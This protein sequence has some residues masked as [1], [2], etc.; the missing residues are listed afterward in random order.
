MWAAQP[1]KKG[2]V[3]LGA[4]EQVQADAGVERAGQGEHGLGDRLARARLPADEHVALHQRDRHRLAV[5]VQPD[6][7]R[8]P[9]RELPGVAVGP[10]PRLGGRQRIA[11]DDLHL[12]QARVVGPAGDPDLA[13][14]Q[15]GGDRL[16]L[17]LD[18]GDG[19]A[20]R[21]PHQQPITRQGQPVGD[22]LWDAVVEVGESGVA[23]GEGPLSAH[24]GASLDQRGPGS[25][26]GYPPQAQQG[27]GEQ[28]DCGDPADDACQL[29][30]HDQQRSGCGQ[31]DPPA[32]Q[33]PADE[34]QQP[35]AEGH[36]CWWVQGGRGL[37]DDRRQPDPSNVVAHH[38]VVWH[39]VSFV[40]V[41]K[42]ETKPIAILGA[43]SNSTT[44]TKITAVRNR[45][46]D[47]RW[48][49]GG[50]AVAVWARTAHPPAVR[51]QR[52]GPTARAGPAML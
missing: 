11:V 41:V 15:V 12:R 23:D 46:E 49:E 2:Q 20:G 25:D 26:L 30:Q 51:A 19:L 31:L 50:S 34:Q 40:S 28:Q 6:R 18:L 17:A 1:A 36:A 10:R 22:D 9:R 47:L 8:Q 44:R 13:D 32:P 42:P 29:G 35:R 24:V 37:V 16:R 45:M 52:M 48:R 38:R 27:R 7:D 14:T 33:R 3:D 43:N 39:T 5:L 21:N 4:V